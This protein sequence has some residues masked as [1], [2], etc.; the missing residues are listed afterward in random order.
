MTQTPTQPKLR[1]KTKRQEEREK[2]DL[3]IYTEYHELAANPEQSRVALNQY[4]M[5]KYDFGST[6]TLYTILKRVE[7]RLKAQEEA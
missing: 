6:G 5:E 3:A 2:R 1:M 4:F 7:A